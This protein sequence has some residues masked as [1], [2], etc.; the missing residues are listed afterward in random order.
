MTK[1]METEEL[2]QQIKDLLNK[3]GLTFGEVR[4]FFD[5]LQYLSD[6]KKKDFIAFVGKDTRLIYPLYINFKAKL[7]AL[8]SDNKEEEWAKI[9]ANE[10][11]ELERYIKEKG[12]PE[13]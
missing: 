7:K 6:Q 9:V 1:N 8:A 12:I 4:A 13:K 10:V 3:S 2:N 5:G 11:K